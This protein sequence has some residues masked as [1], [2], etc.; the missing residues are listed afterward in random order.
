MQS[1]LIE[2][3]ANSLGLQATLVQT[4]DGGGKLTITLPIPEMTGGHSLYEIQADVLSHAIE[5]LTLLRDTAR[6]LD[7]RGA[8]A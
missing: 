5:R 6:A 8:M 4:L 1:L 7:A 3:Q 2:R